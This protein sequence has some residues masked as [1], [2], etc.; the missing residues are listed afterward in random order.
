MTKSLAELK[1]ENSAFLAAKANAVAEIKR[2]QEHRATLL[3]TSTV[4]EII[5]ID[6]EMRR[7]KI[8]V[9]IAEARARGLMGE[10]FF[11]REE[12]KRWAGVAMPTDAELAKLLDIVLAAHPGDFRHNLEEFRRAFYAVGRL[13]RLGEP[14]D[15]RYFVSMVDDANEILRARRL[16]SANGD[17]FC[18]AVL[19]WGDVCWREADA[20]VGQPL[21]LGLAKIYQGT[22]ARPVWRDILSG[23]ANLP[24]P[25]PPRNMRA[26]SSSYPEP[27]VR[28]RYGDGREV[29]PS[30]PLWAQ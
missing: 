25:L 16:E 26:S 14:S 4:D 2:L 9:E 30:A 20:S 6:D 7:Q 12:A 10:L 27:R 29:D 24:P 23:A 18:A 28:I 11:T 22:P 1:S 17:M 21:E 19:A 15:D 8:M 3:R 13:G 5:E